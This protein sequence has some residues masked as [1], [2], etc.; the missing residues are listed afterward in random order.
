MTPRPL[1]AL[2]LG[3]GASRFGAEAERGLPAGARAALDLVRREQLPLRPA[4]TAPSTARLPPT[5]DM[6]IRP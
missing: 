1:P 5:A 4:P 2:R 3:V 6:Q